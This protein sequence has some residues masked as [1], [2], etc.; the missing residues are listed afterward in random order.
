MN[1]TVQS[2][3]YLIFFSIILIIITLFC[4][5]LGFGRLFGIYGIMEYCLLSMLILID[6]LV[7]YKVYKLYA[8]QPKAIMLLLGLECCSILL[9]FAFIYIDQSLLDWQITNFIL[10]AVGLEGFEG[11]EQGLNMLAVLC[12]IIYPF[13]GI[14]CLFT[15]LG[16][17]NKSATRKESFIN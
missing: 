6:I 12:G 14:G 15:G 17:I 7:I 5:G 2:I 13:I 1:K 11:D 4:G 9:W 10:Q 8:M 3:I 16:I